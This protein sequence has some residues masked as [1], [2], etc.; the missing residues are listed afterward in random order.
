MITVPEEFKKYNQFIIYRL[1]W[2]AKAGKNSKIPYNIKDPSKGLIHTN[3][4]SQMSYAA[5]AQEYAKLDPAVY[6]VGFV[7]TESDPFWFLDVDNAAE[8]GQWSTLANELMARTQGAFLEVSQSGSGLHMFGSGELPEGHAN[9]NIPLGLEL[10]TWGRFVALTG[11]HARGDAA[12]NIGEQMTAIIDSY[13]TREDSESGELA[14]WTTAPVLPGAGIPDD[15]ALIAK[16]MNHKPKS[17]AFTGG[18]TFADLFTN[19]EDKLNEW[20]D[21]DRSSIDAA[22]AQHL[23]FWSGKNCEQMKRIMWRSE[24]VRDKWHKHKR[25]IEMTILSA[26]TNQKDVYGGDA[27]FSDRI[28]AEAVTI[29]GI[30]KLSTEL[31]ELNVNRLTK[32][33]LAA[34]IVK[35]A[36]NSGHEITKSAVLQ[37]GETTER[38]NFIDLKSSGSPKTTIEN[39]IV[40]LNHYRI[41]TRYNVIKKEVEIIIP[42]FVSS[43]DNLDNNCIAHI[44]SL[45]C[46]HGLTPSVVDDYITIVADSK[47]HNPVV[48]WVRS[49]DWDGVDRLPLLLESLKTADSNPFHMTLLRKYLVSGIVAA[50]NPTGVES[51]GILVLQGPQG[52]GK[53]RWFSRLFGSDDWFKDGA[54]IN[55][56][57]KDT[58]SQAVQYWGVELGEL[59]ATFKRSD[60]ASLKA[61]ITSGTDQFRKPYER[62]AVKLPRRTVFCGTVNEGQYLHDET[63]NRRFWTIEVTDRI[64]SEHTIDV[65]QIWAQMF[66]EWQCGATHYLNSEEM[67]ELNNSNLKHEAFT[68]WDE[69][70]GGAYN[71]QTPCERPMTASDIARELGF[72]NIS[73]KDLNEISQ[74]VRKQFGVQSEKRKEG[75]FFPMPSLKVF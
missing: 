31:K 21:G 29:E 25:Y 9:K 60:I 28:A 67:R 38:V 13:F 5:A 15:D 47:Q 36:K 48:D 73:K 11:N 52:A 10:Y 64:D 51:A 33:S 40:L 46:R 4:A 66:C 6:G 65:Q 61:F 43:Y 35:T 18:V 12:F 22:L 17:Q 19:N 75:R 49:K 55:P 20:Y 8:D 23:A 27:D 69:R 71:R 7:F 74:A 39:L 41:E 26:C 72:D 14:E 62:K 53:T 58:I 2:D 34:Q 59:D 42:D 63:G 70:I 37:A 1:Q 54:L 44:R 57:D 30:E 3:P 56:D 16:L 24:L 32:E 50:F 45:C 68:V